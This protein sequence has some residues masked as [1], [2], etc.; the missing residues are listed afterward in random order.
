MSGPVKRVLPLLDRILVSKFTPP[1]QT[2]GGVF[3]PDSAT[4]NLNLGVVVAVGP[5]RPA[6]GSHPAVVPTLKEGDRVLLPQFGET[7]VK[8]DGKELYLYREEDVLAK[9]E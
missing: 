9:V 6:E 7:E 1:K 8:I 3:L 5:G 2:A 4:S